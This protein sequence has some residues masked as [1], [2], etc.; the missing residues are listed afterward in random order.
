[1]NPND[2][3]NQNR[4]GTGLN[5]DILQGQWRQFRGNIKE[6]WG[7]LTDDEMTQAEG[8]WDKLVGFIQQRYGETRENIERELSRLLEGGKVQ[9][10]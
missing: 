1:M 5:K 10:R 3:I 7:D 4:Q 6:R 2:Q 8:N 9:S